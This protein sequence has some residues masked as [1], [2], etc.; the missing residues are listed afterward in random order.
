MKKKALLLLIFLNFTF[1]LFGQ[2]GA[3]R[4]TMSNEG[5][6]L[7]FVF[8]SFEKYNSGISLTTVASA[9]Y[10]DTICNP[11]PCVST[12]SQWELLVKANTADI[13]GDNGNNLALSNIEIEIVGNDGAAT[14]NT[15]ISLLN[16]DQNLVSN[17]T[18]HAP[19]TYTTLTITYNIGTNIPLLG[20][21][22]DN[23]FVDL[24]FTLQT[25]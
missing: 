7:Y 6:T 9:Y 15:P 2:S 10:I 5:S 14:Y 4:L 11:L 21:T 18:Q 19:G 24:I 25:Q 13:V 12:G 16:T 1:I 20:E 22:P 8:N 23:Y 17:G 3:A